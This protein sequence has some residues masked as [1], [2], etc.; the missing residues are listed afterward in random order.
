MGKKTFK[1]AVTVVFAIC[2][3]NMITATASLAFDA[4]LS[5]TV[6]LFSN[7]VGEKAISYMSNAAIALVCLLVP[8]LVCFIFSFFTDQKMVFYIASAVMALF[9]A[10]TCM[11]FLF[12][13]RT[14]AVKEFDM[15]NFAACTEFF[16]SLVA[17]AVT[18][19]IPCACFTVNAVNL[20]KHPKEQSKEAQNEEA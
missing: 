20:F 17:L 11:G 8:T 19:L 5:K 15:T 4:Y 9:V 3:L 13:L 6:L 2:V 10:A 12:D 1:T 7:T 16:T 18:S 14:L